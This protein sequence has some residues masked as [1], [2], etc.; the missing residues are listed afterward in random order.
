[1]LFKRNQ[2]IDGYSNMDNHLVFPLAIPDR[3]KIVNILV[4]FI[5]VQIMRIRRGFAEK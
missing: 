2:I 3:P 4:V 5:P 1:M